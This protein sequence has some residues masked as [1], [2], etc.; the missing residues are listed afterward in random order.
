MVARSGCLADAHT[1]ISSL[2]PHSEAMG[3]G[4]E[5]GRWIGPGVGGNG[6]GIP[7]LIPAT[8]RVTQ[9][10]QICSCDFAGTDKIS[11]D[12]IGC[13]CGVTWGK[14]VALQPAPTYLALD[15]ACL[16]QRKLGF[17]PESYTKSRTLGDPQLASRLADAILRANQHRR[18]QHNHSVS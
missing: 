18:L 15:L 1:P 3:R 9:A 11:P 4:E 12:H 6:C 10:A 5:T 7:T 8:N 16:S 13:S 17:C 14:G 2:L